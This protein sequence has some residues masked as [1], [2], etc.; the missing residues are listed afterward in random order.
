MLTT[1]CPE[2]TL[3]T[4]GMVI[5]KPLENMGELPQ[6]EDGSIIGDSGFPMA[7][8]ME[9]YVSAGEKDKELV[10]YPEDGKGGGRIVSIPLFRSLAKVSVSVWRR[11]VRTT[12]W[13]Q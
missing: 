13:W 1:I 11:T 12:R 5:T 3:K 4:L 10:L 8:Y 9:A 6:E 7:N 2:G